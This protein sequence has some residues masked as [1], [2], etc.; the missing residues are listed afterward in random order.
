MQCPLRPLA[1][2]NK[3]NLIVPTIIYLLEKLLKAYKSKY[4]YRGGSRI[5]RRGG[6]GH[7]LKER[8]ITVES[9]G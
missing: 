4:C 2:Q 8:A 9:S 7:T 1:V 5:F 3:A 6:R